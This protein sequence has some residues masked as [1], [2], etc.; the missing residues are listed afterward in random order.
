MFGE[1]FVLDR[2]GAYRQDYRHL[3][4]G[5]T[6]HSD[7]FNDRTGER[8]ASYWMFTAWHVDACAFIS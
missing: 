4:A 2:E 3:S 6:T 8:M 7:F 5:Y 1:M